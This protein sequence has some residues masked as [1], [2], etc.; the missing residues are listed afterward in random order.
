MSHKLHHS[1]FENWYT[2][3]TAVVL[4]S[5]ATHLHVQAE[6]VRAPVRGLEQETFIHIVILRSLMEIRMVQPLVAL[7]RREQS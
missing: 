3:V 6:L 4:T 2:Q 1:I 7:A 5:L